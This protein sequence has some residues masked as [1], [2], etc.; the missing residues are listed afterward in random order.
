MT[1]WSYAGEL[2][3]S[4]YACPKVVP[5]PEKLGDYFCEALDELLQAVATTVGGAETF[6]A[7]SESAATAIVEES[8][9]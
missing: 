3:L 9:K 5:Q 4:I 6:H 7:R 8:Q 2:R 1:V